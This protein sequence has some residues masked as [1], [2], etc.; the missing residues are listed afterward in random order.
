MEEID[1]PPYSVLFK[2]NLREIS[3][4]DISKFSVFL[5]SIASISESIISSSESYAKIKSAF[6]IFIF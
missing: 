1:N 6:F 4:T 5:R 2:N 3:F